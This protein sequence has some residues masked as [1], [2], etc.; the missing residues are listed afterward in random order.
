M[1]NYHLK[2]VFVFLFVSLLAGNSI[3][4]AQTEEE[5][6]AMWVFNIAA[7]V[8]WENEDAISK[9][10]IGV[11]SDKTTYNALKVI[12][13]TRTIHNKSVEI[14]LYRN[15]TS[16]KDVHI[17]FV[18]RNENGYADVI[19]NEFMGQNVLIISDR[20]KDERLSVVN[21]LAIGEQAKAFTIN[22]PLADKQR[23]K[24]SKVLLKL[25][26]SEEV[27]R[28][29]FSETERQLRIEQEKLEEQQKKILA[30]QKRLKKQIEQIAQQNK[31]IEEKESLIEEKEKAIKEQSIRLD[32]TKAEVAQSNR[33]LVRNN[34]LVIAQ[35]RLLQKRQKEMA[36][37]EQRMKTIDEEL[38]EKEKVLA[39][40]DKELG[41]TQQVVESQQEI[42]LLFIIGSIIIIIL[43]F[44]TLRGYVKKQK[45]NQ[46]LNEQNIAIN[47]QKEEIL[48]QSKQLEMINSELEKLSIVASK[49]D[50]AV[51]ILDANGDFEWVNA[52]FT[53]MYGYT[54]QL[55]KH[56]LDQNIVK[57]SVNP[58][59]E[60]IFKR[61]REVKETI[62]YENENQTRSGDPLWVQTTLNP[63]LN[64]QGKVVKFI[65]IDTDITKLK[66]AEIE[67]RQKSEELTVQK[68][69]LK[70]QNER[71]DFQNSQ[72]KSSIQ[73]AKNIQTAILPSLSQLQ[74]FFNAFVIFRPK[75]IVSGDF[76]WYVKL[77]AKD[78]L[79][80]KTFVA[81][82]DCTGHG[83]PGAF[84]SL[85][86]SRMLNEIVLERKI[87]N[88]AEILETL[89]QRVK[90]ALRQ[91]ETDNHDGMDL[92]LCRFEEKENNQFKVKFAGAK[93]P[94]YVKRTTNSDIEVFDGTR[95]SIGGVFIKNKKPFQ[96][97]TFMVDKGDFLWLA[98]DG[99]IDQNDETRKRFGSPRFVDVLNTIKDLPLSKQ[100]QKLEQTLDNYMGD[101]DQRDDITVLGIE[102]RH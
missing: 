44:L 95:R 39:E 45:I 99:Y 60:D 89:D 42:I 101:A 65:T 87:V 24:F 50:N 86:A 53:R 68:D 80:E 4:H 54:L 9:F 77:P 59:I 78:G 72:I 84:M 3:V 31:E 88:P 33:E 74:E 16:I 13:K 92:T 55:L 49:T 58:D 93:R 17:L 22:K 64:E 1:K 52:G 40:R 29:L 100:Q 34:K 79:S 19:Y 38:V 81:A 36:E 26:G 75:D 32:S 82:V 10:K 15:Y 35:Q 56:E 11:Y 27:I 7:G 67:I 12:A 90:T 51:T 5:Q 102:V 6:R 71:I 18:T 76:Y 57:A 61:A 20:L 73:Y 96:S 69:E 47:K 8:T 30:Q 91:D 37:K 23:L 43:T 94:V 46:K 63:I 85:V 62:I 97:K 41:E 98:S 25:G 2:S 70:R 28:D 66:E 14:T 21:F 48:S 83:V